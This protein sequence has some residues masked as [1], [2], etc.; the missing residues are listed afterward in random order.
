MVFINGVLA[1]AED[2]EVLNFNILHKN[3]RFNVTK[4]KYGNQY[5]ET[6]E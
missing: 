6:E 3:L 5:I 2:K 4:D 1:S